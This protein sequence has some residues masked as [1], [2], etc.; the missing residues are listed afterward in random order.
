ME[1][2]YTNMVKVSKDAMAG[3]ANVA[4]ARISMRKEDLLNQEKAIEKYAYERNGEQVKFFKDIVT[5]PSNAH[6]RPGFQQMMAYAASHGSKLLYVYEISRLGRDMVSTLELVKE[7]E[8]KYKLKVI[9]V[10]PNEQFMNSQDPA[11]RNL[12]LGIFSWV[13]EW[14]RRNLKERTRNAL[15]AKKMMIEKDGYFMSKKG[16]K[17]TRLGRPEREIDWKK[18]DEYV[19][20]GISKSNI[21]KLMDFNYIWFLRKLERR[22]L[23][24]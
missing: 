9:S 1:I 7:M 21:A 4:Y 8:T 24:S 12:T 15:E 20:K 6:E 10:S 2:I 13:A 14:E 3:P 17:V 22:S 23:S 16:R 11:F 19:S 18:V 5:G